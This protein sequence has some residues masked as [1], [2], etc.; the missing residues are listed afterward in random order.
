[1]AA[2]P[3]PKA[4]P[5]RP[6]IIKRVKTGKSGPARYAPTDED[7]QLVEGMVAAGLTRPVVAGLMGISPTTLR[8]HFREQLDNG[9]ANATHR[10]AMGLYENATTPTPLYPGGN[11][12]A[13]IF[14]LKARAGWKETDR[15]EITGADGEPVAHAYDIK[16]LD[17]LPVAELARLYQQAVTPP[18]RS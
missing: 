7:R 3:K 18:N 1:M 2:K 14:W 5:K 9:D 11:V 17:K 15:R 8:K 13:Q 6:A 4:E 12:V 16:D 10:V